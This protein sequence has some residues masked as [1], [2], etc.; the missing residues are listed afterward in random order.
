[1][2][3]IGKPQLYRYELKTDT[4]EK[5]LEHDSKSV[6]PTVGLND[7]ILFSY[8]KQNNK[9][10]KIKKMQPDGKESQT[11]VKIQ[12][13]CWAPQILKDGSLVFFG[14]AN[15][16]TLPVDD[17]LPHGE[18]AFVVDKG[19]FSTTEKTVALTTV[20]GFFPAVS[21]ELPEEHQLIRYIDSMSKVMSCKRDGSDKKE[22][23][24]PSEGEEVFGLSSSLDG[25]TVTTLGKAFGNSESESHILLLK[26][27]QEPINLTK[28]FLPARNAQ[29]A[30]SRDGQTIIFSRQMP[31]QRKHLF[32]INKDGTNLKQLT[33]NENRDD[34]FPAISP[35][36]N[37][38]A[39]SSTKDH[40]TYHIRRLD[41]GNKK[42]EKLTRGFV[43]IHVSFSPDGDQLVFTSNRGGLKVETPLSFFFNPQAYGDTYILDINSRKITQITSSPYEDST[44]TWVRC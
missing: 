32:S 24:R 43:D 23:F 37:Y 7:E 31:G 30:I 1:M 33:S 15:L 44:P 28:G 38:A 13:H 5:I 27:G 10:W 4:I 19:M 39:F 36:G 42:V 41:L 17:A 6:Y 16:N 35:C 21:Q 26:E 8:Q 3:H 25:Y 40:I 2:R 9:C 14:T 12:Q 18:G 22:I 29:P 20:R 34:V 11:I